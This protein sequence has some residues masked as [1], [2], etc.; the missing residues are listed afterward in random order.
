MSFSFEGGLVIG[1]GLRA[2]SLLHNR[3]FESL[4]VNCVFSLTGTLKALGGSGNR[5]LKCLP[6]GDKLADSDG[7]TQV[8]LTATP[9]PF[10][11]GHGRY[12][13]E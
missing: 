12:M 5:C 6:L 2:E 3:K 4:K 11:V 1:E 8:V 9:G 10:S 7:S 13:K